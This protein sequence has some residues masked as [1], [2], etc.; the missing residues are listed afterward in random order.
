MKKIRVGIL[1]GG[2]SA[3]HEVSIRSAKNV[4]DALDKSKYEPVLI[5]ISKKGEWLTLPTTYFLQGDSK[6][7]ALPEKSSPQTPLSVDIVYKQNI[8]VVFPV[9]HG[10]MG[11]DGTVQGMLKLLGIPFVGPGVLSSAVSMDKDVAKRLLRDAGIPIVPFLVFRYLEKGKIS[12]EAIKK[13]LGLPFFVKPANLG[14]SV[15][16]YKV[17][18]ENEFDN[19]IKDAFAYDQ[20][21]LIEKGINAREIECGVLGNEEM[22]ASVLGEIIPHHEFYD[23][24]AKYLDEEGAGLQ[25][26]AE[27]A[28]EHV[29]MIQDLAIK[30]C[31]ALGVEGMARVDFFLDRDTSEV[32][33]NEINTIPGFTSISMYPKLWQESGVSYQELVNQLISLAM[34]RQSREDSLSTTR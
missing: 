6:E 16:V 24:A 2:Q 32:Y 7:Y 22:K 33:V 28:Q 1:F 34:A 3:E 20:K 12:F 19:A 14:S 13:G 11:E 29:K 25:I 23:Y 27:L 10:P 21:I 5:G 26:P 17:H 9:L 4:Y 31:R 8:D 18:S 30:T 15:G